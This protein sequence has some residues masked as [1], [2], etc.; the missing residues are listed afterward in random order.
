MRQQPQKCELSDTPVFIS[1][2]YNAY[3]YWKLFELD[4]AGMVGSGYICV[5]SVRGYI[6][7]PQITPMRMR[8]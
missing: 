2:N 1:Y 8:D 7:H 4:G 5:I 6:R 3:E